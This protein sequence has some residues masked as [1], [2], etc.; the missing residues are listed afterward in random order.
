MTDTLNG[1]EKAGKWEAAYAAIRKEATENKEE[2]LARLGA[3][4]GLVEQEGW[5]ADMTTAAALLGAGV[6]LAQA[7]LKELVS[8][9]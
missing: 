7:R 4:I 2:V 5:P 9:E 6:S 8:E 1:T 3:I